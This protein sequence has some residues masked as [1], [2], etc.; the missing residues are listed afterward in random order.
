MRRF[1]LLNILCL[2]LAAQAAWC[3]N[4][5]APIKKIAQ[6]APLLTQATDDTFDSIIQKFTT[7]G[8]PVV[9]L[10]FSD[11]RC[12]GCRILSPLL[13]DLEENSLEK[14]K[15]IQ[16]GYDENPK[17]R[18]RFHV[19]E[20][21][22]YIVFLDQG[23][24]VYSANIGIDMIAAIAGE[25]A[26]ENGAFLSV[27][28]N[29]KS[30][31]ETEWALTKI[32][33]KHL[34]E[35]RLLINTLERLRA[36][37]ESVFDPA[38]PDTVLWKNFSLF[39]SNYN[40]L[41]LGVQIKLLSTTPPTLEISFSEK[42]KAILGNDASLAS[43]A[44]QM[45]DNESSQLSCGYKLTA[46]IKNIQERLVEAQAP[47]ASADLDSFFQSNLPPECTSLINKLAEGGK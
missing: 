14:I 45:D 35:L 17:L 2:F 36:L 21:I 32:S 15:V 16:I 40:K 25:I 46:L 30:A 6:K 23:K 24:L 1:F 44:C 42:T 26:A 41:S 33:L 43:G 3:E 38:K 13:K 39:E 20:S 22:P 37:T 8:S 28:L 12:P 31:L 5:S 11:S 27:C 29:I 4:A 18:E 7:K 47:V 19:P 10:D 9:I 34:T